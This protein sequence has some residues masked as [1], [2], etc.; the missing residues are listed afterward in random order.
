MKKEKINWN[1]VG[2]NKIHRKFIIPIG[3]LT[4]EEAKEKVKELKKMYTKD[5]D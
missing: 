1:I 2:E 5:S 4:K 3:D